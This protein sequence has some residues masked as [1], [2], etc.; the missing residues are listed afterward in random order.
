MKYLLMTGVA[1]ATFATITTPAAA[2]GANP[3]IGAYGGYG[4]T[5]GDTSTGPSLDPSGADYGV[6]AG[7][8]ASHL[9]GESAGSNALA[10]LGA[11]EVY[12]GRS[13]ADDT[14]GASNA[15]KNYE[16]GIRVRPG[17]AFLDRLSPVDVA[18]YGIIGYRRANYEGIAGG[19]TFDETYNGF[20]LGIGTEL[21]A[22][23]NVGVRL[24]YT[25]VWYGDKN[26]FDPSEDNVR[27]GVAY[28]F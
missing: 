17:L 28:H 24:D 13:N 25:H 10:M 20:E 18:P 22:Y 6:M 7:F 9:L 5:D 12:Y 4:W 3:Y 16:Y 14:A 1:L 19:A 15:E 26:G 11:L 8:Q 27:L 2:Q 21:I 23:D